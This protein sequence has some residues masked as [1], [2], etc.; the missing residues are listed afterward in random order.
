MHTK[1]TT[2]DVTQAT[3]QG[4]VWL[5]EANLHLRNILKFLESTPNIYI[6]IYTHFTTSLL[7]N[8]ICSLY[9]CQLHIL[10]QPYPN[11]LAIVHVT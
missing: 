8:F 3:G 2:T 10:V 11:T 6:Y 1:I 9:A 4:R 5:R 7:K